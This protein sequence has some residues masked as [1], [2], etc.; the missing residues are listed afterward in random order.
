MKTKLTLP[1]AAV[2]MTA[3]AQGQSLIPNIWESSYITTT[4]T[5]DG[6]SYR[7]QYRAD[8]KINNRD[9]SN[10]TIKLCDH[11]SIY[12]IFGDDEFDYEFDNGFIK[13]DDIETSG[14]DFTFGFYSKNSPAINDAFI[15]AARNTYNNQILSPA[16]QI[17]EP[18]VMSLIFAFGVITLTK[19]RR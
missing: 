17:P 10:I 8:A 19:R 14:K 16:C 2:L 18:N 3:F 5:Y 6:S 7:Y 9:I 13:F 15:K 4:V 12:D 11:S 1:L